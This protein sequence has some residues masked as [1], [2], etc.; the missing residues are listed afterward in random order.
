MS[1]GGGAD[2]VG[3]VDA[4]LAQAVGDADLG[5][6][7]RRGAEGGRQQRHGQEHAQGVAFGDVHCLVLF[8]VYACGSVRR[9]PAGDG[10]QASAAHPSNVEDVASAG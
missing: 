6:A 3:D 5:L 1:L 8:F 7:L 9:R 2:F 10:G 4:E